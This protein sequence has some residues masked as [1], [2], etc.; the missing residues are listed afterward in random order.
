M[1][2]GRYGVSLSLIAVVSLCAGQGCPGLG[3]P[4]SA[5]D[6]KNSNPVDR[7]IL[8]SVLS[9]DT[10]EFPEDSTSETARGINPGNG[11]GR[12]C[13]LGHTVLQRF[14]FLLDRGLALAATL[15]A[16]LL[17][18]GVDPHLQGTFRVRGKNVAYKA[19]FSAFDIDGDGTPDGSGQP[20]ITPAALRL[21]VDPDG[22]GV[23]E[24]FL[25]TL[26]T[27]RPTTDNAGAGELY[28][29]PGVLVAESNNDV[30]AY[31]NW[32]RTNPAARWNEGWTSGSI[33][34]DYHVDA[35]HVRVDVATLADTSVQKTIRSTAIFKANRF[36]VTQFEYAAR[37]LRGT[38]YALMNAQ[39]TGG[40]LERQTQA[41]LELGSC[42]L[43]VSGCANID[44]AGMDFLDAAEGT[45]TDW[46]AD[47][48]EAPTF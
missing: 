45:E 33:R 42:G 7:T 11:T 37:T 34:A 40:G 18:H 31:V 48:P 6:G 20:G 4:G 13:A 19:D 28:L 22:D 44:P 39:A 3:R 29:H 2:N 35:A 9:L 32:D 27:T 25:C 36:G 15:N 10:D 47:F 1:S 26:V 23:Y 41:C 21:W 17:D 14:H 46:P 8:P 24:R 43:S 12:Y 16:D 30:R 38:G 5:D